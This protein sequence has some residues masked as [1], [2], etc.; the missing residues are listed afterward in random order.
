MIPSIIVVTFNRPHSLTRLLDF[1]NQSVYPTGENINLII[2][3]DFQNSA[4]HQQVVE[5]SKLFQWKFGEKVIIEHTY[6]LGLRKHVITCGDLSEK[7]GSIIMLEDDLAISPFFY[8]YAQ[9]AL[10]YYQQDQNIAGI[11]LY[12]HK[13]NFSNRMPFELIG[14]YS[15][16]IYFLQI[17]SSWGQAWTQS[18]WT[19]FR[20]WYDKGQNITI[21]DKLPDPIRNW[22]ESSWLKY[23]I[24]YLVS[25]NKYFVYPKV[26]LS[27]NF[28][29]SGTH[30]LES[31]TSYQVPLAYSWGEKY[32]FQLIKD[33]IN[34]YDSFFELD[35]DVFKKINPSLADKNFVVDLYGLKNL[36]IFDQE[37]AIS[38]KA[39]AGE[40]VNSYGLELKPMPLNVICVIK[41]NY[42]S[43]ATKESFIN[44]YSPANLK[45]IEW[46]YF[47]GKADF[48]NIS[49]ILFEK[50]FKK[51]SKV[52]RMNII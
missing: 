38:N 39:T 51:F 47:F 31:D 17:A 18:Q 11:S 9:Q 48:K 13:K 28:G 14:D 52:L 2:S 36:A 27:T 10:N 46:T 50:I 32:R 41:G 49:K 6:N 8:T 33:S 42:F 7:Y 23:F 21:Q 20:M 34:I 45:G 26:S 35:E 25:E 44:N 1:L 40:I 22:P 24:K 30:N 12:T 19:G 43:L 5:I 29:D 37:Y 15:S 16:D 4:L 3:I